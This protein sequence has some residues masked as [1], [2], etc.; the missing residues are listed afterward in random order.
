MGSL[1]Q[2][3][4]RWV[5]RRLVWLLVIIAMLAAAE[6]LTSSWNAYAPR[7]E[8]R[9]V[10]T[11]GRSEVQQDAER[12]GEEVARRMKDLDKATLGAVDDLIRK[13]DEEIRDKSAHQSQANDLTLCL[14]IRGAPCRKYVDG[15]K[16]DIEISLLRQGREYAKTIRSLKA[17]T[18]TWTSASAELERLRLIHVAAYA[19]LWAVE[20]EW[21][22][23]VKNTPS[24]LL[25]C[26]PCAPPYW[27]LVDIKER[28]GPLYAT[29]QRAYEAWSR[30][31]LLVDGLKLPGKMP[32][33]EVQRDRI[34]ELLRPLREQLAK[35][36][37][38][39]W[40]EVL[41]ELV[42][43]QLNAAIAI[44]ASVIVAPIAIKAFSYFVV[45]PLASRWPAIRLLPD[46]S[47]T[48]EGASASADG[49]S[50]LPKVSAVSQSINI[51]A[52]QELLVHPEYIQGSAVHGEKD[53]K[54]L[55]D[56]SYPISSLAAGL[57]SLTRVRTTSAE[58]VVVSAT[59]DPF[60]EIG[61][62][63]LPDNS[64]MV[65]QPQRLIGVV[66]PRN[67]PI[68]ITSHWRLGSLNAWLTL[69]LRYLV[70]HGPARL[71]IEGCRG[72]R[73]ERSGSGRSIN[74][75]ATIGFSANLA[76]SVTRCETFGAYLMGKQELFNDK[77]SD[78]A[79]F[80]VYEETPH[81]GKKA[82]VTGR[83]IEGIADTVLKI[84][85]I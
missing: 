27:R 84:V 68:R 28:H 19:P 12:K 33:F 21:R 73:I 24:I 85:G 74:Q 46:S 63:S 23:L 60:S 56:W 32:R 50:G 39:T 9:S 76:Y 65:F 62:I 77:F 18:I 11:Q 13:I 59:S 15:L 22:Q 75:A 43:S 41:V 52:S 80:Y 81:F 17:Q 31:R 72:V 35:L 5:L 44:L 79:G 34:E 7:S 54:W 29:N 6:F 4:S 49:A 83:G 14:L 48:I 78:A 3:A 26:P 71:I 69:Q 82:G 8:A 36:D 2:T 47:G 42:K 61:V 30:Q 38:K 70:F 10:L 51:D 66:Q 58:S 25:S 40:F 1:L 20:E 64:A 16:V 67:R 45:A 55:L 37:V 57:F 53:T